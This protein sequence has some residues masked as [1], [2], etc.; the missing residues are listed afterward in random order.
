MV[1]PLVQS[2][3]SLENLMVVMK[4]LKKADRLAGEKVFF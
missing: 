4:A 2:K 1:E 3:E